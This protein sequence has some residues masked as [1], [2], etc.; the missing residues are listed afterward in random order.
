MKSFTQLKMSGFAI[1]DYL[2]I[3]RFDHWTK[4]IFIIPG[5]VGSLTFNEIPVFDGLVYNILV[6]FISAGFIASGNYVINEWLDKEFDSHHPLKKNRPCVDGDLN[7]ILVYAEY[8]FFVA[9]GLLLASTINNLFLITS[10]VFAL[11]GIIYNVEP[12]RTKAK[13]ILM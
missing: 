1:V 7:P 5:I 2:K 8:V 4:H 12:F 3:A 6:G 9:V 10:A 13:P 11:C